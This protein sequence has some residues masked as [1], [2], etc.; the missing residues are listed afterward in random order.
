MFNTISVKKAA[1]KLQ[2]SE[3][4]IQKLC[5]NVRIKDVKRL[6]R[7]GY[8]WMIPADAEKPC[9]LRKHQKAVRKEVEDAY[10]H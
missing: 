4:R 5:R 6:K 2:I 10:E 7:F 8:S 1:E 9:D 3:Q